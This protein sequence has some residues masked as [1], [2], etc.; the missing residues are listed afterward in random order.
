ML[1]PWRSVWPGEVG[2]LLNLVG[3]PGLWHRLYSSLGEGEIT[4]D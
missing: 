1:L 2:F 3:R 4:A